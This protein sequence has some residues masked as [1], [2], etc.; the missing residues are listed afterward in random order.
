MSSSS[1]DESE[2]ASAKVDSPIKSPFSS[3]KLEFHPNRVVTK[4]KKKVSFV[5]EIE[6]D[7]YTIWIELF[8]VHA[9]AQKVVHHIICNQEKKILPPLMLILK[10]GQPLTPQ[11]INRFISPSLLISL[12]LFWKRDPP[13]WL[14]ESV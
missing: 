3:N 12:P 10:C 8:E 14:L 13:P 7:Q 5:L 9:C 4:I 11:C 2:H 6:K 1:G